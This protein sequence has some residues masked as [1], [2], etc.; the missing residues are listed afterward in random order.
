MEQCVRKGYR[1]DNPAALVKLPKNT[2]PKRHHRSVHYT[3]AGEALIR[4][5]QSGGMENHKAVD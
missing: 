5:Q 4:I 1:S 3:E 2:K